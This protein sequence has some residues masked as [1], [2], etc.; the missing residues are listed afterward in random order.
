MGM[1]IL[2]W[3]WLVLGLLLVVVE[4]T[5]S[6]GFYVMFFGVAALIVGVLAKLHL[7]EPVW[8]QVLLFSLLSVGSLALFRSRLLAWL[9]I[10][11]PKPR[12]DP[13][14]GEIATV[15]EDLAPGS[16]GRVELR[17]TPWSARNSTRHTLRQ[18]ARCRVLRVE[19]LMLHV[20][21]EGAHA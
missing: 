13:I 11:P 8:L 17:G 20:E 3:H 15:V 4:V 18:G 12:V 7:A 16:V 14:I 5:G 21:P 19:G 2:W 9:Q 1:A 10:E 6:G